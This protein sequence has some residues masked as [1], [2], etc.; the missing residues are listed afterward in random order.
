LPDA[1]EKQL[2]VR[3]RVPAFEV[4]ENTKVALKGGDQVVAIP[5]MQVLMEVA[6]CRPMKTAFILRCAVMKLG[7]CRGL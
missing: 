1:G 2:V 5:S 3:T 6:L 7:F 4:P